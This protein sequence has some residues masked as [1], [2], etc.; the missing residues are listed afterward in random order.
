M[1]T[2]C[3][4]IPVINFVSCR[5][6]TKLSYSAFILCK[7]QY[8]FLFTFH[9]ADNLFCKSASILVSNCFISTSWL[10][11]VIRFTTRSKEKTVLYVCSAVHIFIRSSIVRLGPHTRFPIGGL[12]TSYGHHVTRVMDKHL[13]LT[14]TGTLIARVCLHENWIILFCF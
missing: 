11:L 9:V 6:A 14:L 13:N 4:N 10:S 5:L 7:S 8:S 2:R 1:Y 12:F 3:S